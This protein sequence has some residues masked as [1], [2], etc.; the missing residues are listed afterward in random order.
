VEQTDKTEGNT[1]QIFEHNGQARAVTVM[2]GAALLAQRGASGSKRNSA[3]RRRPAWIELRPC[4]QH[5][6][7]ARPMLAESFSSL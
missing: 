4:I 5:G 3:Q 6:M 1:T 7:A 2:C